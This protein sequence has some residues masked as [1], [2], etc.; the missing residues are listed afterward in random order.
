MPEQQY[1]LIVIGAGPGGYVAA[2]RAAQLGMKVLIVEK[3]SV[4]GGV[5]LNE[6]CIPSKAL[7]ESSEHFAMA[8][9]D[10]A[11]HG[12]IVD[13]PRFDLKVMM[14]RKAEIVAGLAAGVSFLLKKNGVS[15][16]HG[17]ASIVDRNQYGYYRVSVMLGD[18]SSVD[19]PVEQRQTVD[20]V[21]S[22]F[23][24]KRI[25]LATGSEAVPLPGMPFDGVTVVSASDAL[26]FAQV[27]ERLLVVG[28][29]FI[30]LE[31]ASVW[32]RLGARVT[33][34]EAA[35]RILPG[36]DSQISEMLLRQLRKQGLEFMLGAS[37]QGVCSTDGSTKARVIYGEAQQE[38]ECDRLLV[39][40]G[41][42]PATSGLGLEQ[43]AVAR[44]V[45][46][47]L[48]VDAY[49]Q[50][51]ASGIYAV[52][53]LV[54]GPMLAHKASAEAVACVERMSGQASTVDYDLIPSTVYTNPEAAFIG[55]SEEQLK[56]AGVAY[57]CGR[58][59]F[60]SS[61]RARCM[62]LTDGFVKVLA[63]AETDQLLGVHIVGRHASELI[64]EASALMT[65]GATA[66][67]LTVICHAHPTLS[68]VLKE[69]A[70]NAHN[71]AIHA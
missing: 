68:E 16:L 9:R 12:V 30:G 56:E 44:D 31:L 67:D 54:P 26:G 11:R 13:A 22:I 5:C 4:P 59:N 50:T 3:R 2:I 28:G 7:L 40:V 29:G 18:E 39:A 35:P 51:T 53:D 60:Y 21:L 43:F 34:I 52:G 24:A 10:L 27:P 64:A 47:R 58:F 61:G 17:S 1:D 45:G 63:H 57:R 46:G 20:S 33:I 23:I 55:K 41:R 19:S 65:F 66:R 71:E 42:R 36:A 6:G 38:M 48:Q 69:A 8:G 25:L 37:V 15:L 14:E 49:Y 62:G 70:L 32:Q